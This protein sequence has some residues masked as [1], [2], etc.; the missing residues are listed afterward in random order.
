MILKRPK[1]GIQADVSQAI[2]Y[3]VDI[4]GSDEMAAKAVGS[5]WL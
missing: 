5:S 3:G 1:T 2:A 4:L